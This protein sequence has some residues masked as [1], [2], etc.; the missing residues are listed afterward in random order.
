V[1]L[2]SRVLEGV[3]FV[4]TVVA[5]PVLMA[6][7]ASDAERRLAFG[8][9]G[10]YMP[11]GAALMI[12]ASPPLLAAW[13]WRGVWAALV[14]AIAVCALALA[15]QARRYPGVKSG[16]QRSPASIRA[17]LRQPVPWLLGAAFAVYTLQFYTIMVWLPTY[18]LRTRGIEAAQS[19]L[20]TVLFIVFNAAGNLAGARLVHR[21]VARGAAIATSLALTSVCFVGIFSAALP[22]AA[23][24]GLVLAYGFAA[25]V[26][27]PMA[28]SGMA[29][30]RAPAEAGALQGLIV[31]ISNIGTFIGPPLVAGV[32]TWSGS[33]D[34]ALGVVLAA[35]ALGMTSAWGI[36]RLE[37]R[38][39]PPLPSPGE[40]T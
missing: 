37:S 22:D 6:A 1:L 15:A 29:Y 21:K 12:A 11:V 23:R 31:Q 14:A 16:A 40:T 30:A 2:V 19:A 25:G 24:Y 10:T 27:P 20:L 17:G 9:W 4:A 35:A 3:G 8:L 7:A 33:W 39:P 18:L 13:G 5:A 34:A 32:V 38:R 36:Q 28:T 26:I